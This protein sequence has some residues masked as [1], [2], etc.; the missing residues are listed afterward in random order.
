VTGTSQLFL[1]MWVACGI[2]GAMIAGSKGRNAAAWGI[3][4]FLFGLI[5]L[6]VI[7]LLPAKKP[8]Y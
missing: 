1:V 6:V 7:A 3:L 2:G 5:G 4:G 8:A